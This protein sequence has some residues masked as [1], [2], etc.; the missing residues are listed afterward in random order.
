MEAIRNHNGY[1]QLNNEETDITLSVK[2]IS[3]LYPVDLMLE[4]VNNDF[5]ELEILDKDEVIQQL[6]Q[7][8]KSEQEYTALLQARINELTT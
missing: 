7:L 3:Q 4:I 6:T 1:L 8:L 2:H 5:E